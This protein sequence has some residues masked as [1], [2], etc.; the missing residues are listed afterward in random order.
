MQMKILDEKFLKTFH[1]DLGQV[2]MRTPPLHEYKRFV[3]FV[4]EQNIYENKVDLCGDGGELS[5]RVLT[6]GRVCHL[7]DSDQS[8]ELHK[9]YDFYARTLH[10]M[11]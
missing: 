1:R 9:A 6:K 4:N 7:N 2:V 3:F 11:E 10:D 8:L 5:R